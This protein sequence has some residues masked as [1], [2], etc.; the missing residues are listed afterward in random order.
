MLISLADS[1]F[2]VKPGYLCV[3]RKNHRVDCH[4]HFMAIRPHIE[5]DVVTTRFFKGA[6]D[7][8]KAKTLVRD[9][10]DCSSAELDEL[11]KFEGKQRAA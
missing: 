1:N 10:L 11:H 2:R 6:K 4:S 3:E 8:G 7:I 5:I 9:V